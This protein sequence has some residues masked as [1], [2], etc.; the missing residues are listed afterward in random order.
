MTYS[1]DCSKIQKE[2]LYEPLYND[3][4]VQLEELVKIYGKN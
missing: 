2:L 1:I 3:F 4:D